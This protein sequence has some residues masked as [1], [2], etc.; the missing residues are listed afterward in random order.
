MADLSKSQQTALAGAGIASVGAFLPWMTVTVLGSTAT[1]RGVEADGQLVLV[2]VAIVAANVLFASWRKYNHLLTMLF[3]LGIAG[4]AVMYI[5]DP[6][7]GAEFT[8]YRQQQLAENF[9]QPAIGLYVTA[10]GG[11]VAAAGGYMA[12]DSDDSFETVRPA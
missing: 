1:K 9:I 6:T 5:S 8:T 10:F 7:I 3:G 2:A 11:L 4:L 12:Y